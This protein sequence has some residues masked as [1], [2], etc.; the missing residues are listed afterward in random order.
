MARTIDTQHVKSAPPNA[1]ER[2]IDVHGHA[3]SLMARRTEDGSAWI[4]RILR[5]SMQ[6]SSTLFRRPVLDDRSP[7]HDKAAI[8]REFSGTGRTEQEALNDLEGK[9]RAAL[10]EAVRPD[11]VGQA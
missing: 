2:E 8:V 4:A 6:S 9:L 1:G 7:I 11:A 3:Y 10:T 5:Y